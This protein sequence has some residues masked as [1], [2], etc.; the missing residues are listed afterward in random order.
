MATQQ[1]ELVTKLVADI[2]QFQ[3]GMSKAVNK[4]KEVDDAVKK[5]TG[6]IKRGMSV[7]GR[8]VLKVIAPLTLLSRAIKRVLANT[9]RLIRDFGSV[10]RFFAFGA[11]FGG[12]GIAGILTLPAKLAESSRDIRQWSESLGISAQTLQE[13]QVAGESVGFTASKMADV[14]KDVEDKI[15]DFVLT[16]GGEASQIFRALNVDLKQLVGLRPDQVLIKLAEMT[17]HL[18]TQE[19]TFV[20]EALANDAV[21]LLPLVRDNAKEFE[22]IAKAANASGRIIDPGEMRR[23]DRFNKAIKDLKFSWEALKKEIALQFADRTIKALEKL[24]AFL[25][26]QDLA[27]I[28]RDI[29]NTI[30]NIFRKIIGFFTKFLR[31]FGEVVVQMLRRI[32]KL[33]NFLSPNTNQKFNRQVTDELAS[34]PRKAKAF[35]DKSISSF[36]PSI[37]SELTSPTEKAASMIE[38]WTNSLESGQTYL[39]NF[40]DSLQETTAET[41]K[42]AQNLHEVMAVQ[43][44]K[45]QVKREEEERERKR[46]ADMLRAQQLQE[47][48]AREKFVKDFKMVSS[49]MSS[50]TKEILTPD[51][52]NIQRKKFL[53]DDIKSIME[54]IQD[55]TK[56]GTEPMSEFFKSALS[57]D[58]INFE[59]WITAL[60]EAGKLNEET[61]KAYRKSAEDLQ[62]LV[63]VGGLATPQTRRKFE[64]E[65]QLSDDLK[66]K[67]KEGQTKFTEQ[68]LEIMFSKAAAA[69]G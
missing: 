65:F 3:D 52:K 31:T 23:L 34:D 35:L 11:G 61:A 43:I 38:G 51:K 18:S 69:G 30:V 10:G 9:A 44:T 12:L 45:L 8:S 1:E 14:F 64:F 20:F 48:R 24:K 25:K 41:P 53:D 2:K 54:D 26:E 62:K 17:K 40:N 59:K 4:A 29:A 46:I 32:D 47:T 57:V 58:I 16:G 49:S 56:K 13:W 37:P 15:G 7:A 68:D 63:D 60:R 55:A 21:R 5:V 28:G 36:I 27:Q 67:I 6:G 42:W 39:A 22:R 19:Q 66:M 33:I 50:F